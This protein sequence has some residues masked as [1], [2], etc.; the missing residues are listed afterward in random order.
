MVHP[1]GASIARRRGALVLTVVALLA[2]SGCH[3]PRAVRTYEYVATYERM[4][5]QYE[6][7]LSLVYVPQDTRLQDYR[8]VV[9]G[10]IGVGRHWVEAQD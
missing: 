10:D 4:T 1:R 8:G 7:L 3:Y 9:I 6:P 5:D 2:A